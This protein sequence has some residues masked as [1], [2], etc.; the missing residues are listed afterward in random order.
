MYRT[1]RYVNIE[2]TNQMKLNG[3]QLKFAQSINA[4]DTYDVW[5]ID[6]F[7]I[8]SI[9]Q[10]PECTEAC[11]MDAFYRN[12]NTSLWSAIT[13]GSVSVL[14]CIT[15][16]NYSYSLNFNGSNA[17][18]AITRRLNL[19]G[20]YAISFGLQIILDG[21]DCG[22]APTDEDITLS[23]SINGSAWMEFERFRSERYPQTTDVVV[24]LP[25]NIR[26]PNMLIQISQQ[27]H[28]RS[29]WAIKNFGI[30][31]PNTCPPT[32]YASVITNISSVPLP[33]PSP[34][35]NTVC[36][37]YNDNFDTGFYKTNLWNT[38]TGVRIAL[39]PC[40]LSHLQHYAM[41]FYSF[42][43]REVTTDP[44]DLRGVEFIRFYLL[45]GST[46]NGCSPPN[47]N[48]GIHVAYRT[49]D[50]L[51]YVTLEYFEPSCCTAGEYFKV[52]LPS[53][54]QT[55][56]V[57][58]VWYQATHTSLESADVWILDDIQIGYTVD[59]IFYEDYF[60][61]TANNAMWFSLAGASVLTPPCGVTHSG[62]ALYFSANGTRQAI[63][64]YLDLRLATALSFYLR[65]GSHEG[66]CESS[67]DMHAISLSWRIYL[68]P[69]VQLNT[70]GFYRDP[71]Y[72]YISLSDNM[73]VTGVQFRLMQTTAPSSNVDV[74]S[75]DDFI[76][77]SMITDTQCTLACYSDDFNN[78]QCSTQ[79]WSSVDGAT[80]TI[81][82]CSN[83]FLGNT[84]YFEGNG[85]RQ[86]VTRALDVRGLYALSFYLHIGSFGGS[87]EP[88]ES[89]ENV[90]LHYRYFN[91]STWVLLKSYDSTAYTR[92]T[93]VIEPIP[94]QVQ[95][96]GVIFRWMQA[97][98]SGAEDDTWSLDNVGFHSPDNCPPN[99]YG[100]TLTE[101]S[102]QPTT[103]S[104]TLSTS[105][106][107][108]VMQSTALATS[109][110]TSTSSVTESLSMSSTTHLVVPS[111]SAME[112][113]PTPSPILDN[114]IETFDQLN[115]GVY[116]QVIAYTCIIAL[117]YDFIIIHRYL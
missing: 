61:N 46:S 95:Q 7:T 36:N 82:P 33:Y 28:M 66:T 80:I 68:G 22:I 41:E 91:S 84:L 35:N 39:Q 56:S 3:V 65:I 4:I 96:P 19:S 79:L 10:R 52:Y 34:T 109:L 112:P 72:V 15:E 18:S 110:V 90:D 51:S 89:G 21:P 32:N 30:Y 101:S 47:S 58:V 43:T 64:Q 2:V 77:H 69:W 100:I 81:P 106:S 103:V 6:T 114:C 1:A 71:R 26:Q 40:S 54:A 102:I 93:R 75:I 73:Q 105:L 60:T 67:D 94:R 5:S 59:N 104:A 116:R 85:I 99:G 11:Y 76:V 55:S 111:T 57:S 24:E 13:G 8:H 108:S 23:Y 117:T 38:V 86:A 63:T 49:G 16:E 17:R 31:S 42:G 37:S 62:H 50:S 45:S 78:G 9:V 14:R 113:T 92:E 97:S 53:A 87:C 12:Y 44:I 29:V 27:N 48:E 88:A 98:H 115:N 70:Y 20:L 107:P 74:W 25:I 83:Q